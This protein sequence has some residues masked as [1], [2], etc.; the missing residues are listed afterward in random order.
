MADRYYVK[1]MPGRTTGTN[2]W[3]VLDRQNSHNPATGTKGASGS[4][5]GYDNKSQA[6]RV[7]DRL[8][9]HRDIPSD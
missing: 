7:A 1:Q 2:N 5:G 9:R 3:F 6:E 8:N 4:V